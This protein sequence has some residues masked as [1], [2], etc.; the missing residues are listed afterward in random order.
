[1][2]PIGLNRPGSFSLGCRARFEYSLVLF[3]VAAESDG[4]RIRI[5]G[6]RKASASQRMSYEKSKAKPELGMSRYDWSKASRGRF[7]ERFAGASR[8]PPIAVRILDDD[9][10]ATFPDIDNQAIHC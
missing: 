7:A 8:Q 1:M 3:V 2:R 5:I 9:L 10:I 6:A 4:A